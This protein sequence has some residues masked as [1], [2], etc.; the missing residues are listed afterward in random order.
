MRGRYI[1]ALGTA[2]SSASMIGPGLGL[3][4]FGWSPAALWLGCGALGMCSC[5]ILARWGDGTAPASEAGAASPALEP[6]E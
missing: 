5:L 2:W 1:G 3:Q 6:A 4:I